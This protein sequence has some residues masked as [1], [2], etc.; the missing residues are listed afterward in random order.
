MYKIYYEEITPYFD[1][2]Y[3]K[4]CLNL[5]TT[6]RRAKY[7][8]M[9]DDAGKARCLASGMILVKAASELGISAWL[10][11]IEVGEYGKPDFSKECGF[12]F[13]ISHS[14]DYVML[15]ISDRPIGVDIQEIKPVKFNI[16]HRFFHKDEIEYLDGIS[17]DMASQ[18]YVEAFYKIWCLK[19]S[20]V[21]CSGRGLGQG[22]DSFSVLERLDDSRIIMDGKYVA[23]VCIF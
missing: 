3:S 22:L 2:A 13:N 6:D 16:A 17:D 10:D 1:E 8:N 9:R 21:K 7:D 23:A 15:G 20:Y 5:I 4:E 19:E 12:H 11:R 14:G 18:S